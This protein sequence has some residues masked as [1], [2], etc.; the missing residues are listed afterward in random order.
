M[1]N[2]CDIKPVAAHIEVLMAWKRGNRLRL[3]P[4]REAQGRTAEIYQEIKTALGLPHVSLIFQ[5]YA[6]YPPFL[7]MHWARL[8]PLV[9]TREFFA[10]ADRLRADAYTRMHNYFDIPDLRARMEALRLSPGA[11]QEVTELIELFH[12]ANP[13]LLLI[14]SAQLQAFEGPVGSITEA[15]APAEHAVFENPPIRVGEEVASP[16]VRKLYDEIK[17]TLDVPLVGTTF[18]ALARWPD[19]LAAYWEVLRGILQ[20]PMYQECLHG[21]RES[22]TQLARELP[23]PFELPLDQL[24]D[25]GMPD[26]GIASV[27]RITEVFVKELAAM[28]LHIVVAKIGME[29]GTRKLL[30]GENAHV[31]EAAA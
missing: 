7:E 11:Q 25:A 24:A 14:E 13:L 22:A 23:G 4:E 15:T 21:I 31:P 27:V 9:S 19:F 10:I 18:R 16:T 2:S 8:R 30:P 5:A 3:V 20:S 17:H 6:A 29:G 1:Q 28:L 12:Y 26:E